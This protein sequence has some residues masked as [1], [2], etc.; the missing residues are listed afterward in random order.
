MRFSVSVPV[1]SLHSTVVAPS[2][3]MAL[4]RRVSTP[5]LDRRQA[6]E[7]REHGQHHR[8]LLGQH[9]HGQGDAGQQRLQPVAPHQPVHE[10]QRQAERQRQ[11]GQLAHQP[12]GLLLQRRALVLHR[13]QR[14]ADAADFAARAGGRDTRHAHGPARPACRHRRTAGRR[15]RAQ[16]V[17]VGRLS[18]SQFSGCATRLPT[19]TASPVSSDSSARTPSADTS[20]GIG[21]NAVA[22]AQ[23]E[24]VAAHHVASGDALRLAVAD[25]QRARTGEVAQGFDG[26]LGLAFLVQGERQ[27]DDARSRRASGPPADHRT[28]G[29]GC[30]P[31]AATGTSARARSR[32]RSTARSGAARR[33]ARWARPRARRW[34]AWAADRP[35][36]ALSAGAVGLASSAA[37][38]GAR[39]DGV[40]LIPGPDRSPPCSRA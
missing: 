29:T 39:S 28:P 4:M 21:R 35:D 33:A 10:H 1:L 34:A 9:G 19:G 37:W 23:H 22:F 14:R 17:R 26:A 40:V 36:S 25:D 8:V 24:Q 15:R 3:S 13:A 20:S 38:R 6:P 11:Q 18:R 32:R 31:P 16:R 12:G 27:R 30:L 2:V 5:S 7:R